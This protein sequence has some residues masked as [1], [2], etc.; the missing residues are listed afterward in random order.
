MCALARKAHWALHNM[1]ALSH[2]VAFRATLKRKA[3]QLY[4]YLIGLLLGRLRFLKK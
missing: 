4:L 3:S 2:W 1:Q